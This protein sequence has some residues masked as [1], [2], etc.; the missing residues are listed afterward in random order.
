[1]LLSRPGA[2]D[3]AATEAPYP[4]IGLLGVTKKTFQDA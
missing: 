4:N 1:M 3:V 2:R